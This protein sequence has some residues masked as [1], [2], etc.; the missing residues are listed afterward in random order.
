MTVQAEDLLAPAGRL[1]AAVL[2]IGVSSDNVN[3]KLEAYLT[4]A[5]VRVADIADAD[6]ADSATKAWAYYRAY[7]GIY[8]QM[9][10]LPSTV[11]FSDEGSGSYL[12]TQMQL[13]KDLRDEALAEFTAL[14]D[15]AA[16]VTEET[17]PVPRASVS[18]PVTYRW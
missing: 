11:E 3:T 14:L 9:V 6:D 2:W 1:D 8:Q 16:V 7:D 4:D 10:R 15:A 17:P 5:A 12:V 18:A 13:M